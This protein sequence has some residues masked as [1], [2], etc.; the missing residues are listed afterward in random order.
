MPNVR[1]LAKLGGVLLMLN[2]VPGKWQCLAA[3]QDGSAL[4]DASQA[5]ALVPFCMMQEDVSS[6]P[7][8]DGLLI[9]LTTQI[10][11]CRD[12]KGRTRRER[13]F[14][15][16]PQR[17]ADRVA[18]AESQGWT[19]S[20]TD[21]VEGVSINWMT[22]PANQRSVTLSHFKPFVPHPESSLVPQSPQTWGENE[23]D[24]SHRP[25]LTLDPLGVRS[26]Q[27][28]MAQGNRET[29]FHPAGREGNNIAYASTSE[30][31]VSIEYR[32][33]L[34]QKTEDPSS[35][36]RNLTLR[37][38]TSGEPDE[39][40]FSPPPGYPLVDLQKDVP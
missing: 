37:S 4:Q 21:P 13:S 9:T 20:V 12:S 24:E 16:H 2:G 27:G 19:V 39:S 35:G 25:M 34:E 17:T 30:Y 22:L 3:G 8:K 14:N 10:K 36:N 29:R 11:T 28:T 7:G 6:H 38:F 26:F 15:Y 5:S 18:S 31:W 33:V 32:V 40:L 23:S 1:L